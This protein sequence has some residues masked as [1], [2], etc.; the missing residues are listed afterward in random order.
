MV[1]CSECGFLASRNV[2]TRRLEE[3]ELEIRAEGALTIAYNTGKPFD[4][5][6]PPICFKQA[7]DF[8][9]IPYS[10]ETT[11]QWNKVS[12]NV[13]DEIQRDRECKFF[14][15]WRQGFTPKEH[16]EMLDREIR[17]RL[18]EKCRVDERRWHIGEIILIVV[19]SGLFI[20]LGAFIS[21]GGL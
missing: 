11:L 3:T 19:L 4:K 7:P 10:E 20:L 18:D 14:T 15:K 6:E 16:Q 12:K 5:Y 13:Y 1:K 8:K 21:R 2:Q 9:F 17:I